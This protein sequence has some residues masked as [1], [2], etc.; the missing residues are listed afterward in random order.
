LKPRTT[1]HAAALL[2][3]GHTSRLLLSGGVTGQRDRSEAEVMAA[4]ARTLGVPDD[5]L[6]LE[7]NSRTT[8]ENL[9]RTVALLTRENLLVSTRTAHLVS[10]PWHMRR[11]SHLARVA[12]GPDV[13]LLCSPHEEGC[14]A[15][16]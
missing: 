11:V 14:T 5:A 9:T 7:N 1:K 13:R 2:L 6:L 8:A 15:T 12:F 3:G 10:C 4:M 16:T